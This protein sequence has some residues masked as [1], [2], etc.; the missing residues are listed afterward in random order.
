MR[1]PWFIETAIPASGSARSSGAIS[2]VKA[3]TLS[4]TTALTFPA[5]TTDDATVYLYYSPDG[6]NWDTIAYTS[7]TIAHTA[8]V[9][10]QRTVI[11][12]IPEHGFIRLIVTNGSA[13]IAITTVKVWYTIQSWES[14]TGANRG[15]IRK[16]AGE[17]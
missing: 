1:Q 6:S 2:L 9:T 10:V 16:D 7:W 14:W 4:I 17:D 5:S 3:R 12:D 11:N 8:S 13:T 15:D